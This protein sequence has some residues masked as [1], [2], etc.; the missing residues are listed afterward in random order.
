[1]DMELI[2]SVLMGNYEKVDWCDVKVGQELA[3]LLQCSN[4]VITAL[5]YILFLEE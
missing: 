4:I 5:S 2:W 1:M 3:T